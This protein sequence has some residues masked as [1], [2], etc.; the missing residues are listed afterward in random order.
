MIRFR[1]TL[2]FAAV[3]SD[4]K[5]AMAAFRWRDH[6]GRS[7]GLVSRTLRCRRGSSQGNSHGGIRDG[8]CD[9]IRQIALLRGLPSR[10]Q[11]STT[12]G[13]DGSGGSTASAVIARCD[14]DKMRCIFRK[15]LERRVGTV[16]AGVLLVWARRSLLSSRG[17]SRGGGTDCALRSYSLAIAR[18]APC[19]SNITHC[20][21]A[22]IRLRGDEK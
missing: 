22:D 9:Q 4:R 5:N 20:G 13:L 6:Q 3:C 2:S 10:S 17:S 7:R 14:F 12:L 8:A 21:S 19:G 1:S 11:K 18:A 15:T 16:F